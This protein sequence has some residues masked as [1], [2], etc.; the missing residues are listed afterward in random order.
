MLRRYNYSGL[1]LLLLRYALINEERV[2]G[3]TVCAN[4]RFKNS[5]VVNRCSESETLQNTMIKS[6]GLVLKMSA[7]LATNTCNENL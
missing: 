3:R 6:S 2:L 1:T 5:S 4:A 7:C